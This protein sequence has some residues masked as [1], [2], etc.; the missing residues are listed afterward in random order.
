MGV[1]KRRLAQLVIGYQAESEREYIG[2]RLY[3]CKSQV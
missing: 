1:F 3:F 2:I